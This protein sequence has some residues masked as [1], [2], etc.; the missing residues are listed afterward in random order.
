MILI[1]YRDYAIGASADSLIVLDGLP[2]QKHQQIAIK[3]LQAHRRKIAASRRQLDGSLKAAKIETL[4]TFYYYY[5]YHNS[6]NMIIIIMII[7][8]MII[9]IIIPGD[10]DPGKM[11][12]PPD[13]G[14]EGDELGSLSLS[15][16]SHF[17][18]EGFYL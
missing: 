9:I 3:G 16:D 2:I 17:Q 18:G 14:F 6:N 13:M 11:G 15:Q 1:R 7:K 8:I 10:F 12:F 5:Y 4:P